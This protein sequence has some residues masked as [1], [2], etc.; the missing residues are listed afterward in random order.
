M[1]KQT[2]QLVYQ[3]YDGHCAYCGVPMDYKEMQVDH[4]IAQR[5]L[6][7]QKKK[8]LEDINDI[9]NLNPACRSCNKFKDTFPIEVFRSNIEYQ[10]KK[11]RSY[12]ATFRIAER[13]G[14]ITCNEQHKVKFY[15]ELKEVS[16]G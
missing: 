16:N 14:M 3:K 7:E 10:I 11:F 2:R 6:T 12:H 1:N 8:Q 9:S 5:N 15:F 4:I 13:F